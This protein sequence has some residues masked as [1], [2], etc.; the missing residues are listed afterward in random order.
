MI[1][2]EFMSETKPKAIFI[3]YQLGLEWPFAL[4][5]IEWAGNELNGSTVNEKT[6]R[7]LGIKDIR[8]KA[9]RSLQAIPTYKDWVEGTNG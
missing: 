3:G 9:G 1:Y 7:R 5:N 2:T 6:V 8:N 4:F